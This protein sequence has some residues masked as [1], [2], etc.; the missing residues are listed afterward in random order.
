M[1]RAVRSTAPLFHTAGASPLLGAAAVGDGGP[2]ESAPPPRAPPRS[3]A[4]HFHIAPG[5]RGDGGADS[6]VVNPL[7]AEGEGGHARSPLL[8]STADDGA[9]AGGDGVRAWG[10]PAALSRQLSV[11]AAVTVSARDKAVTVLLWCAASARSAC[12]RADGRMTRVTVVRRSGAAWRACFALDA[13]GVR[14]PLAAH[15]V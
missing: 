4:P 5:R 14:M 12:A 10:D 8:V 13:C 7:T 11:D 9:G 15:V 6:G 1:S 3:T 2:A